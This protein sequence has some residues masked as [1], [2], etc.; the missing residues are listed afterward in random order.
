MSTFTLCID[1]HTPLTIPEA[2]KNVMWQDA[3]GA[4]YLNIYY[5]ERTSCGEY[6]RAYDC[7]QDVTVEEM[8]R[9]I[10]IVDDCGHC[11]INVLANICDACE[12]EQ[13]QK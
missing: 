1:C 4:V 9:D 11:G 8:L 13:E 10:L 5:N 7:V 12:E 3:D 2:L 6:S